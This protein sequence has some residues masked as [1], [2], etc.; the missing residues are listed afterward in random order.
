MPAISAV[1]DTRLL[2]SYLL[3]QG[4]TLSRI[5]DHWEKGYFVAV[6]SLPVLGEL[7]EV[8]DR[9]CLHHVMSAD[10]QALFDVIE[11]GANLVPGELFVS[12]LRLNPTN[13]I[14]LACAVEGEADYLVTATAELLD[15]RSYQGIKIITPGVFIDILDAIE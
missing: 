9:P 10:P 3:T 13:D 15:L 8:V 1:L 12:F 6:A 14:F 7:I 11:R 4:D 5:V 2:I